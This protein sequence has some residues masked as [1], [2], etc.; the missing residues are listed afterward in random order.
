MFSTIN[1]LRAVL[2]DIGL[3][4]GQPSLDVQRL[5]GR[6]PKRSEFVQYMAPNELAIP[7]L[8]RGGDG[9]DLDPLREVLTDG[10]SIGLDVEALIALAEKLR[11]PPFGVLPA[12]ALGNRPAH[13]ATGDVTAYVIGWAV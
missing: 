11:E 12:S 8:G 6:E 5:E 4:F 13:V 3:D 1:T 2:A 10:Q 9:M 7:D